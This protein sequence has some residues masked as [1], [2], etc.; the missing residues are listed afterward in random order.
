M[1]GDRL[2]TEKLDAKDIIIKKLIFDNMRSCRHSED[3]EKHCFSLLYG[4]T[5]LQ[6]DASQDDTIS[7]VIDWFYEKLMKLSLIN[8]VE[9]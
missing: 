9:Q 2:V 6:I 5:T 3:E 1:L 4:H 7:E 8:M